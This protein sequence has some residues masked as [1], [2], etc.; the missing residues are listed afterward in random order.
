MCAETEAEVCFR[1]W[2]GCGLHVEA[3]LADV[4]V[5]QRCKCREEAV[6]S[7]TFVKWSHGLEIETVD[8]RTLTEEKLRE[9]H[10]FSKSLMEEEYESYH[11]H[12]MFHDVLYIF[13]QTE[14]KEIVGLSHW[15]H[16]ALQSDTLKSTLTLVIQGKAFPF[17]R[18][19]SVYNF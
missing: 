8:P 7:D 10:R 4:P 1:T 11:R 6:K 9:Y 17:E 5:D 13:R 3:C 2:A 12:V 19:S 14:S 18:N 16:I 15:R